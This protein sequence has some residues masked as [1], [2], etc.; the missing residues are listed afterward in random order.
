MGLLQREEKGRVLTAHCTLMVYISAVA[1]TSKQPCI[2]TVCRIYN[3]AKKNLFIQK[4]I[5]SIAGFEPMTFQS[6]VHYSNH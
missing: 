1:N 4:K 2:Y 3:V 6:V 5:K